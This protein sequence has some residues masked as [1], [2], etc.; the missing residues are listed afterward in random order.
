M[1]EVILEGVH[2]FAF[3]DAEVLQHPGDGAIPV[4][5]RALRAIDGFVD[6]RVAAGIT[7]QSR[8]NIGPLFRCRRRRRPG[9]SRQIAPALIIGFMGAPVLGSRLI[10]LKASPLG[11]TPI[12]LRT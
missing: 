6:V 8:S 12:L 5:G 4:A 2:R 10:E 3:D 7:A 1:A 11:S 9:S